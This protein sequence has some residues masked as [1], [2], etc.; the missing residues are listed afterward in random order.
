MCKVDNERWAYIRHKLKED[1]AE[2]SSEEEQEES[3]SEKESEDKDEEGWLVLKHLAYPQN[4][5]PATVIPLKAAN[6]VSCLTMPLNDKRTMAIG[7]IDGHINFLDLVTGK[8]TLIQEK[9]QLIPNK[10]KKD[11]KS[12]KPE[13]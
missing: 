5:K 6:K 10:P 13:K 4:D 7:Y 12:D 8:F 1:K 3:S 9:M 11:E 2:S